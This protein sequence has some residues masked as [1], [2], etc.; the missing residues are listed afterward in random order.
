MIR[1]LDLTNGSLDTTAPD[2]TI[3]RQYLGGLGLAARLVVDNADLSLPPLHPDLPVV[4]A[5]GCLTATG[6]PG[7]NRV[8]FYGISPLTGLGAPSWMGG[9]FGTALAR[10]GTLALVLEGR[11]PQ[12]SIVIVQEEGVRI[13]PRPDLWGL[14]VSETRQALER[15]YPNLEAV[16]IGPA[17]E[18]LVSI[19]AVR[20]D[21]S[22]SA[23]RCGQGAMLGSKNIKA[24]LA[25]GRARFPVAD[26]EALRAVSR[27]TLEAIRK[28]PFLN[29]IQG[30]IGTP[31]LVAPVND[32]H[33]FPTG[34]HQE[35]YFPTASKIHGEFIAKKYVC[36]RTTCP[37]CPVRCRLHVRVDGQEWDAP[38]YESLWAFSADNRCDDY[39]LIVRAVALCNE[40]GLDTISAG[41]TIAFYR[42]YSGTMDD[43]SNILD[44]V[45]QIAYREGDGKV[46]AGGSRAAAAHWGVD[47][48]MQVKGLELA[49]YDPRKLTGMALSYATTNR[50]GCHS[51]AWTVGDEL[52]GKDFTGEDLAR[53]VFDY[54]NAGCVRDSIIMCTFLNGVT[55][56]YFTRALTAVLG[57]EVTEAEVT[58][59]G[60]RIHTLERTVNVLRGVDSSQDTLPRRILD[61]L[62]APAKYRDG[63]AAYYRIR[64]WDA[65]G[66]PSAERLE[67]LGLGFLSARAA[68]VD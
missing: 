57:A 26:P 28:D 59:T 11:A 10:S 67:Q 34:N 65:A 37:G 50:G 22:H 20:G 42:E 62:V 51:R 8:C 68:V 39:P 55:S 66:R 61:G 40:L 35:R 5:V 38:E 6:F 47:Y 48:A 18:H 21:E 41:N 7:A 36:E 58:R 1:R 56:A 19:A 33:A 17:G 14:T 45:R 52:S 25:G 12:P 60:E 32:F 49:A 31:N 3:V 24:I 63:M 9:K 43:P 64:D 16:M 53:K 30:P 54:S 44:L 23:A 4:V 29:E 15:D 13:V 27:E 46:L 2:P